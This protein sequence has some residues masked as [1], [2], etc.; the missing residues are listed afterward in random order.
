MQMA[1]E[2]KKISTTKFHPLTSGKKVYSAWE[3]SMACWHFC[4][5]LAWNRL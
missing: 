3:I 4:L 2:A 5:I 1:G